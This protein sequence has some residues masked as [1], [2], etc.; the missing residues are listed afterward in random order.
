MF[1]RIP[2]LFN[3]PEPEL[4]QQPYC[5]EH[6]RDMGRAVPKRILS[7]DAYGALLTVA[8]SRAVIVDAY[9]HGD[10]RPGHGGEWVIEVHGAYG[11]QE[12]RWT[13]E[14]WQAF[15]EVFLAPLYVAGELEGETWLRICQVIAQNHPNGQLA[16][17]VDNVVDATRRV[18][19]ASRL[20]GGKTDE[21]GA[22]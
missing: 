18:R 2:R 17:T 11:W 8:A 15:Y 6:L 5:L 4:D 7:S 22:A 19:A 3:R 14:Q 20:F 1:A 9:T 16:S 21:G 13:P 12:P 10:P